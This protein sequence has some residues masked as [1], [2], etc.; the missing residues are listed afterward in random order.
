MNFNFAAV[1]DDTD[2]HFSGVQVDPAV[3][4]VLLLVYFGYTLLFRKAIN[5]I[6]TV[7]TDRIF[8]RFAPKNRPL[9]STFGLLIT[10]NN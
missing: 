4:F 7:E 3:V 2:V 10:G 1:T 5:S 6:K 8:L 9:T